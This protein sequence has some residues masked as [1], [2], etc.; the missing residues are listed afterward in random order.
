[1]TVTFSA[2]AIIAL[3]VALATIP[4][5]LPG[6]WLMI[7]V[8]LVAA[9]VGA[10]PWTAWAI[11]AGVAALAELAELRLLTTLGARYGGSR[12]AFWGAIAGGFAGLFVGL[13]IPLVGSLVTALLGSFL[14][15]AIVTFGETRSAGRATRVG[16]G[17]LL[18]R[19]ASVVLKVG[20]GMAV[21]GVA[22]WEML[23][24]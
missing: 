3:V 24:R 9:V 5:G 8:L 12:R 21:L 19:V 7:A 23:L 15:A 1:M 4:F 17:I 18:A 14:G 20:V 22:V 6:L 16:W 10:F 11:L 2:A 13:P